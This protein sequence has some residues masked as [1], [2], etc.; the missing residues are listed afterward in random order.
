MHRRQRGFCSSH[1]TRRALHSSGQSN[2]IGMSAKVA[3]CRRI[4]A[5]HA[6][7]F[8][9]RS[10]N[11][12]SFRNGSGWRLHSG[13]G[14]D[15]ENVMQAQRGPSSVSRS[16][17]GTYSRGGRTYQSAFSDRKLSGHSVGGLEVGFPLGL[18]S[19]A[20]V[21]PV[22]GCFLAQ[23]VRAVKDRD[24]LHSTHRDRAVLGSF[25]RRSPSMNFYLPSPA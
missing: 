22:C 3:R 25:S 18:L 12:R 9:L 7:S 2:A 16:P 5:S 8:R 17:N 21:P 14:A 15:V 10:N 6:A 11:A 24:G 20:P 13:R 1:L 19:N 4:L 23:P